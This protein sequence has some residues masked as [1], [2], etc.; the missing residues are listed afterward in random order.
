MSS[1]VHDSKNSKNNEDRNGESNER[2]MEVKK[3]QT[4]FAPL[5]LNV[6]VNFIKKLLGKKAA[7]RKRC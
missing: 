1:I 2:F 3:G 7:R 6:V 5:G 4:S